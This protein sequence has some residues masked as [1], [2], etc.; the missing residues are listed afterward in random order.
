MSEKMK[1]LIDPGQSTWG[2]SRHDVLGRCLRMYGYSYV[3]KEPR[4]TTGPQMFG[5]LA[6]LVLAHHYM[7]IMCEHKR[8][9]NEYLAP[10][11]ALAVRLQDEPDWELLLS[12]GVEEFYKQYRD[13]YAYADKGWTPLAIEKELKMQL[14]QGED[15]FLYTQRLDL[16]VRS[17]S[18]GKV[19][20]V[21]HKTASR[22]GVRPFEV[23]LQMVGCQIFGEQ[24]YGREFGGVLIN[25]LKKPG[26]D[27]VWKFSRHVLDIGE[28]FKK[29]FKPTVLHRRRELAKLEASGIPVSSWPMAISD[30]ICWTRYG[31][32]PYI[33]KC[34]QGTDTIPAQTQGL[35]IP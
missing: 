13:E 31:H 1:K 26:K 25:L 14:W 15:P 27:G 33:H 3:L 17:A 23:S 24:I 7:Q 9:E 12:P 19:Y 8:I 32:C 6:H 2:S 28:G 18:T 30:Q 34:R 10:L 21:D 16:I 5:T 22:P 29:A 11:D 20:I 4:E 35:Q